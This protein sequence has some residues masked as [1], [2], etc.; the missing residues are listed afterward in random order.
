MN[1]DHDDHDHYDDDYN[2]NNNKKKYI[3]CERKVGI[4]A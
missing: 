1:Y 4:Q 2:N 3:T